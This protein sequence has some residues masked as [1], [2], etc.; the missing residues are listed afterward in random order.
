MKFCTLIIQ[1]FPKS[2][3]PTLNCDPLT[4]PH[5]DKTT[6]SPPNRPITRQKNANTHPGTE[7]QKVLSTHRDPEL[8]EKEKLERKAKKEAKE[9]QK[10][11]EATRKEAAKQHVEELRAQQ[12]IE[13]QDEESEHQRQPGT[14]QLEHLH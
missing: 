7:A 9:R 13:L 10:E 8:I 2:K 4:M 12:A 5:H 14:R 1:R 3:P 6:D 11:E